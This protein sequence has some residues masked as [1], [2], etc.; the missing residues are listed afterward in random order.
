M[1]RTA[2]ATLRPPGRDDWLRPSSLSNVLV[3]SA[4]ATAAVAWLILV[5]ADGWD[6]YGTPLRVRAYAPAHPMLRPSGWLGHSLGMAGLLMMA[7]PVI[8][9]VRKKWK[10]LAH[11]GQLRHWLNVHIFCGIFGPVLV[12]FHAA[13]KFNGLIAVAYWSMVLVVLSGFVG[14]YLYVRIPRTIRGVEMG[15]EEILARAN[16]L[17]SEL[18]A[19]GLDAALVR[20]LV[21]EVSA[22]RGSRLLA[23]DE[24]LRQTLARRQARRAL[25]HAG[26][27]PDLVREA[28][29]LSRERSFL[30]RRLR[31]LERTRRLFAM[32]HVFHQPLVYVMFLIAALHISLAVYLGYAFMP[33]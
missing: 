26:A 4:A 5:V 28:L 6:Y 32:W 1:D 17:R 11:L 12:T 20:P 7:V 2:P 8:Y 25:L 9:S 27:A 18:A 14:R 23:L 29:S 15:Y 30:L 33:W 3:V 24:P 31:Y 13:M 10:R 21:P 16:Q 22:E 19:T